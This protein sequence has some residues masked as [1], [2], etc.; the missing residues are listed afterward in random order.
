MRPLRPACGTVSN[1]QLLVLP[2]I[3]RIIAPGAVTTQ[4][5]SVPPASRS[6]TDVAGSSDRRLATAHPPEP[7]PTTT[8]S[9][10]SIPS[11]PA[12]AFEAEAG[13]LWKFWQGCR[14]WPLLARQA[15]DLVDQAVT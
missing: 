1:A 6:A 9:K 2:A 10:L 12:F 4:L 15:F 13:P 8:K 7:P 3:I 14:F 5:S 11:P